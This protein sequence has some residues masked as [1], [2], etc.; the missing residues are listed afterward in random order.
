M[1]EDQA[2]HRRAIEVRGQ[3]RADRLLE[4]DASSHRRAQWMSMVAAMAFLGL[5]TY[6][7]ASGRVVAGG[8]TLAVPV[9][10]FV[11]SHL[12]RLW[13]LIRDRN[14]VEPESEELPNP[15]P[16]R[17]RMRPPPPPR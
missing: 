10:Q 1:A 2:A 5:G 4:T 11:L 15:P 8:W 7:V 16:R 6:L 12:Q 13:K 3:D 17:D 14:R 9:A